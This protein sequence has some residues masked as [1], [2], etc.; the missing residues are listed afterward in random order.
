M[1]SLLAD[2]TK[3]LTERVQKSFIFALQLNDA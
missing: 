3:M 2:V 1:A